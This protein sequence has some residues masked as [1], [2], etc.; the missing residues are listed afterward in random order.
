MLSTRS[1]QCCAFCGAGASTGPWRCCHSFPRHA[2]ER[3]EGFEVVA[4]FVYKARIV[5]FGGPYERCV[6]WGLGKWEFV[7]FLAG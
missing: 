1:S 5:L 7:P 2:Q 4:D 6:F 3:R